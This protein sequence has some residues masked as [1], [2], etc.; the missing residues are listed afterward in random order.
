MGINECI[1]AVSRLLFFFALLFFVLVI[2]VPVILVLVV[3]VLIFLVLP[4][5]LF[6]P[7]TIFDK[8]IEN[9]Y[10]CVAV[11]RIPRP[12]RPLRRFLGRH[13]SGLM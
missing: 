9:I 3:F 6:F 8:R 12:P 1:N 10:L 5:C 4:V 13:K 7:D 11:T 2:F